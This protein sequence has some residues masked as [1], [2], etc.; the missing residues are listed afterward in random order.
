MAEVKKPS[1]SSIVKKYIFWWNIAIPSVIL[2]ITI[3]LMIFPQIQ[4]LKDQMT[5]KAKI[6]SAVVQDYFDDAFRL[7]RVYSTSLNVREPSSFSIEYFM[8]S[9]YFHHMFAVN[10]SSHDVLELVSPLG[11]V[12]GRFFFILPFHHQNLETLTLFRLI[13]PPFPKRSL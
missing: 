6:S 12:K 1:L 3:V 5:H 13:T 10:K 11:A 9:R 8:V 4:I 7:I 2:S